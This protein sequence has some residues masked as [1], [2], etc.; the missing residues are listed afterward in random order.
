VTALRA[1]GW[2]QDP[3]A[4]HDR[5]WFSDG[6]PTSLVRDNGVDSRDPPPDVPCPTTLVP[7]EISNQASGDDDPHHDDNCGREESYDALD[8]PTLWGFS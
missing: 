6:V 3:Y 5:R 4:K 1:E 7:I 8:Y 2:Y